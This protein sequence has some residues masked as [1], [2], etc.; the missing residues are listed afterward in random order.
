MSG[1][2][3][4]ARSPSSYYGSRS[5]SGGSQLDM[6]AKIA[7]M[8]SAMPAELREQFQRL[9]TADEKTRSA[10]LAAFDE[11]TRTAVQLILQHMA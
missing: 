9:A 3:R 1:Q 5:R 7:A 11:K 2:E 4:P 6:K 8:L 10:A